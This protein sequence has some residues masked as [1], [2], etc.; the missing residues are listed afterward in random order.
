MVVSRSVM[1]SNWASEKPISE[2]LHHPT[3]IPKVA[4]RGWQSCHHIWCHE[5]WWGAVNFGGQRWFG[6]LFTTLC[7]KLA[8]KTEGGEEVDGD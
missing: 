2:R 5:I 6:V 4:Q 7:R 1:S 8:V 3:W